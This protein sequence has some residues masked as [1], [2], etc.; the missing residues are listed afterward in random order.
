M[1]HAPTDN[2]YIVNRAPGTTTLNAIVRTSSVKLG[3]SGTNG[4]YKPESDTN[5]YTDGY[6]DIGLNYVGYPDGIP[7]RLSTVTVETDG[8]ITKG[9]ITQSSPDPNNKGSLTQLSSD[10]EFTFT[11]SSIVPNGASLY[12]QIVNAKTRT[13]ITVPL[14]YKDGDEYYA[15]MY[16]KFVPF[17][18]STSG[19]DTIYSFVFAHGTTAVSLDVKITNGTSNATVTINSDP[20]ISFNAGTVEY[21][22]STF[23]LTMSLSNTDSSINIMSKNGGQNFFGGEY[24][25]VFM[26]SGSAASSITDKVD[27]GVYV[28][29]EKNKK[30]ATT[31]TGEDSVMMTSALITIT[32]DATF[33]G[34]PQTPLCYGIFEQGDFMTTHVIY[35]D[36]S[37][38]QVC[39]PL[40]YY[41]TIPNL[42]YYVFTVNENNT[43]TVTPCDMNRVGE[44][45]EFTP[46]ATYTFIPFV[47]DIPV[48]QTLIVRTVRVS[49]LFALIDKLQTRVT[50]LE[51]EYKTESLLSR[52]ERLERNTAHIT[53]NMSQP[54]DEII[55]A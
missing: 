45:T 8:G 38:T 49:E 13:R 26:V 33:N 46:N 51:T 17:T 25:V 27:Q 1:A 29:S 21:N 41:V 28:Y 55:P 16:S 35:K 20:E 7:A 2:D 47:S 53:S 4:L 30:L 32:T 18:I 23:A 48:S 44:Q 12:D 36:D 37:Y 54:G 42:P 19:N 34:Q 43:V 10:A 11:T 5:R 24:I 52:V 6:H 50:T 39:A 15:F 31:L 22:P 3:A 9:V 14:L 40:Q